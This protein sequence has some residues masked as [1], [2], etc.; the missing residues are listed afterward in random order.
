MRVETAFPS[1]RNFEAALLSR[2]ATEMGD[3]GEAFGA[4]RATLYGLAG[5]GDLAATA[6]SSHSHNRKCGRLLGQGKPVQAIR[7]EM[8]VLPESIRAAAA[9]LRWIRSGRPEAPLAAVA[10]GLAAGERF[11]MT[12]VLRSFAKARCEALHGR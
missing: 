10:G 2:A 1:G 8:G 3:I 9:V 5:L 4:R 11:D 7:Q 12:D 6:L